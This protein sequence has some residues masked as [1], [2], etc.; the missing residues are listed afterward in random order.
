M[1]NYKII[2]KIYFNKLSKNNDLILSS[3]FSLG[4]WN[5]NIKYEWIILSEIDAVLCMLKN[6]KINPL[7]KLNEASPVCLPNYNMS[8]ELNKKVLIQKCLEDNELSKY[9]PDSPNLNAISRDFFLSVKYIC[10]NIVNICK[11]KR[12]MG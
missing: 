2:Q 9:L 6:L 5:M 8:N 12:F 1:I 4:Q 10:N 11:E 3:G 7:L